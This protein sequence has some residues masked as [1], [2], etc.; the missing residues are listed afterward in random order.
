MPGNDFLPWWLNEVYWQ[1]QVAGTRSLDVFDIH[2]YPDTPDTSNYTLAQKRALA[3]RIFRDYWD[4]TYVS[5][6]GSDI[7]QKWTTFIQPK[8]TIPFRLPRHA[9][10][11]EHD[12]S[13]DSSKRYGVECGHRGRVGLL[14]GAVGCRRLWNSGTGARLPGIAL[15]RA[16]SGESELPWAEA[17]HQLRRTASR[18]RDD[19][20]FGDE[21][22]Q[23]ESGQQL[24]GDER[25]GHSSDGDGAEQGSCDH[26]A[27]RSL[28]STDSRPRR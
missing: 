25:G 12:L 13:R 6:S 5:E 7:N 21:R 20:G 11:C 16:G 10:D 2:A 1:D 9:G 14:D 18:L 19:V 23:S 8:K 28:R 4:P 3:L 22:W 27:P 26:A 17:L 15:G 24:R